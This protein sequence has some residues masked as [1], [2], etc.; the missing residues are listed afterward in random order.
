VSDNETK[1]SAMGE[2]KTKFIET[3]ALLLALDHSA[4]LASY[5]RENFTP[6]ELT[7][8]IYACGD[9]EEEAIRIRREL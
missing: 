5:L 2:P 9:L 3:E 7:T 6:H 8:L 1:G 4:D